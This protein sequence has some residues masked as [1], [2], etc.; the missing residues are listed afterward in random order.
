[1]AGQTS[2]RWTDARFDALAQQGDPLADDVIAE[3]ARFAEVGHPAKL[4]AEIGKHLVLPPEQRSPAIHQYLEDRPSLPDWVDPKKIAS[5]VDFFTEH[6]ITIGTSLFCAS[7]PEAYAAAR[8]ARVLT[9]TARMASDPV[10]RVNET[11]QL[12]FDSMSAGGLDP[13]TGKGYADIRRVRLMHA[14]VR[15]LILNDPAIPKTAAPAPFPAWCPTAGVPINQ[16]DLLG[17]LMTFTQTVF[18]SL[19]RVGAVYQPDEAESYLHAWCVTGHLLGILPDLLPLDLKDAT[20]ITAAIRRRQTAPSEDGRVLGQ[21]LVGAMRDSMPLRILRPIPAAV[22]RWNVGT[23]VAAINGIAGG[24]WLG[25]FIKGSRTLMRGVGLAQQH[26]K[27]IRVLSRHLGHR[28]LGAFV[29]AG[30][31]GS[32]PPFEVPSQLEVRPRTPRTRW[33]L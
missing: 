4:V 6:A 13:A 31:S 10:R 14:A 3:H 23:E 19:D 30:R 2:S 22:V 21:A 33:K 8:G 18:E 1:M 5:S 15:Y 28:V 12:V 32:R 7:L 27:M 29:A 17:T 20:E 16:E 24:R 11:A 9:L 26:D 25:G